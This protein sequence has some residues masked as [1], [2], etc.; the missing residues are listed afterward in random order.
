MVNSSYGYPA[1]PVGYPPPQWRQLA[2]GWVEIAGRGPVQL[3]SRVARL[4][5]RLIDW[6]IMLVVGGSIVVPGVI[7]YSGSLHEVCNASYQCT[8]EP[9]GT[10]LAALLGWALLA[11][12]TA[13]AYEWLMVGLI[14]R[15]LGKMICNVRV[16]RQQDGK[17]IGLGRAFVR[18]V[19]PGTGL[20][21]CG[22]FG[23]IFLA[24]TYFDGS[25]H[26]RTW[27]DM[28]ANDY[29]VVSR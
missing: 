2:S 11:L 22:V 23:L 9:T 5:A 20:A 7:V 24:S 29:V 28:A 19:I 15:T 1:Q 3:A 13:F 21:V 16:V 4:W 27:Y 6:L 25:G 26:K 10:G 8:N 17:R 12:V 14:G 18:C